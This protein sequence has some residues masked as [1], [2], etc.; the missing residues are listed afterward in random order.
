[1][2]STEKI[3]IPI[4]KPRDVNHNILANKVNAAGAHRNKKVE[5]VKHKKKELEYYE[6]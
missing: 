1:M 6:A 3:L 2:K 4:L 5:V